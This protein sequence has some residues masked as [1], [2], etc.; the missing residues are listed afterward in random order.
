[1]TTDERTTARSRSLATAV[2]A[3]WNRFF[4][5]G[6]VE[7]APLPTLLKALTAWSEAHEAREDALQRQVDQLTAIVTD[8]QSRIAE[9]D[10]FAHGGDDMSGVA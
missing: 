1:M 5:L 2:L 9:R 7:A 8:L 10:F 3:A 4:R 6:V